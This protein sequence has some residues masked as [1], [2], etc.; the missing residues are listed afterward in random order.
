MAENE[1]V[2]ALRKAAAGLTYQSETDAEWEVFR[3]PSAGVLSADEV[4]TQGRHPKTAPVVEQPAEEFLKNL[5]EDQDWYGDKERAVAA[6][7]R[8]LL[9]L[10]K[11]QLANPKVFKVGGRKL[12]IYVV[13]QDKDGG[14]TGLRTM[15][16]ET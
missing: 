7:Y 3:W 8:S 9:T 15:A 14:L 10:V 11:K 2:G 6:Q 13:G 4:R 12:T 5:T 1:T 16:V